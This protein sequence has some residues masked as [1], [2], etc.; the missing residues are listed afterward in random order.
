ML[1]KTSK[2]SP[3]KIYLL[4]FI[5]TPENPSSDLEVFGSYYFLL[6]NHSQRLIAVV[7]DVAA[8]APEAATA[9]VLPKSTISV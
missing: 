4:E 2:I 3:V 5:R 6:A 1:H 9:D 8:D 7:V